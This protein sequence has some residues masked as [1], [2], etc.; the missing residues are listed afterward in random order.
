MLTELS[1]L[2]PTFNGK[3]LSLVKQLK[4]QADGITTTGRGKGLSYEI[5]VADDGSTNT[6]VINHN[7]EIDT[8]DN[9]RYILCRQ[10]RGRA[11]TR[12][13]LARTARYAHLLFMDSHMSLENNR[14]IE[15][16]L[17]LDKAEV[18]YGGYTIGGDAGKLKHNLRYIYEM[19]YAM[20][21]KAEIRARNP[22]NDFHTGNFLTRRDIMLRF[23][24]D[25]RF[26]RYGYEDV[27]WGKTLRDN[28]IG[29]TH[30]DNPLMFDRFETNAEFTAKTEEGINTLYTFREELDGYSNLI[31]LGKNIKKL[32]LN[33]AADMIYRMFGKSIKNNISGNKPSLSLFYLYKIIVYARRKP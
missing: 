7:K 32:R 1:I 5:I 24:F 4:K 16:Y 20:N 26:R 22:Y 31:R 14:F 3:C 9:C 18:A 19:R 6:D 30:I 15:N 2:I 13:L 11:A 28:G 25:E 12:N 23:P 33:T 8:L 27:L 21:H 17:A 10:N 29:I